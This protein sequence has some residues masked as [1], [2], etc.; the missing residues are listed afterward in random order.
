MRSPRVF[1]CEPAILTSTQRWVSD[2][3]HRR[4]FEFGFDVGRLR[5]DAY[6][7][8]PWSGLLESFSDVDG[9]LVLGFRQ[10]VIDS[11]TWRGGTDEETEVNGA[12]TSSWLHVEAGMA[13]AAG[14]PVLVAP[15]ARVC[16]GVFAPETWAGA[17]RGT[18][19]EAPKSFVMDEWAKTVVARKCARCG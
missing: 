16:E 15:E 17:L 13:L 6:Q 11:G 10:L 19:L 8:Y 4:L 9:A 7:R 5:R 12:W 18:S 2:G 14:I 3:W 1:V